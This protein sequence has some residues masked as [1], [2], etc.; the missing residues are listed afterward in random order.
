MLQK[1]NG[2]YQ[3]EINTF[4]DYL[5]L[6][7]N[8]FP[9]ASALCQSRGKLSHHA[10]IELNDLSVN[11]FYQEGDYCTWKGHRVLGNDGSTL[12]LPR[13]ESIEEEFGV[14]EFGPNA[15]SSKSLARISYLYDVFNGLVV[16]AQIAGFSVSEADLAWEHLR[17]IKKNDIIIYDRYY[18]SFPLMFKLKSMGAHFCFRMKKDWWT[19]VRDFM[20]SKS[21]DKII[22]FKLP[23]KYTAWA[24]EENIP[25]VIKCR[26][27]KRKN[28]KGDIE[29]FCTSLW[30]KKKYSKSA[31]CNLYKERWNVEEG[32]KLIKARLEVEDFSGVKSIVVKQD[33][34][35]KT[36]LL[37]L[38]SILSNKIK[39]SRKR[40]V[41][42]VINVNKT[43]GLATTK[44]LFLKLASNL[45][46]SEVVT[47]YTEIIS[48][49]FNF[50][51]KGQRFVRN[52]KIHP[53]FSMNYKTA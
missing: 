15:A 12:Q 24:E 32:Y 33:F 16:D 35:A 11:T 39:P 21:N 37:T 22:Y 2:S 27:L 25:K 14:H 30:D 5:G 3:N 31:I 34:Y 9:T 26:L 8:S 18:A 53:K 50:S 23:Q 52:K 45:T 1:N 47:Y 43:I 38:N 46:V 7:A 42:R 13:H 49:K 44:R 17:C 6:S 40:R 41:K 20:G 36:L 28:R 51:R 19:K 29:V 48:D 10:F 4:F